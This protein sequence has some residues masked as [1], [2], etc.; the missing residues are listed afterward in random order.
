MTAPQL[1]WLV[2]SGQVGTYDLSPTV[3]RFDP[4]DP[5]LRATPRQRSR[6]RW[7]PRRDPVAALLGALGERPLDPCY[8]G[9][10]D[11]AAAACLAALRRCGAAPQALAAL[12]EEDLGLVFVL[13]GLSGAYVAAT[14]GG[15][16]EALGLPAP[17]L[18]QALV[19][20]TWEGGRP[21]GVLSV[22]RRY[23]ASAGALA[24]LAVTASR[25][26]QEAL[27]A[28]RAHSVVV[29][30]GFARATGGQGRA[31]RR[32]PTRQALPAS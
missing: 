20:V 24:V 1:R 13:A 23:R 29:A 25:T 5:R 12:G 9:D 10:L 28:T 3:A 32:S 21:E 11:L 17:A 19:L 30:P 7:D 4:A 14:R 18:R 8:G 15:P 6:A 22:L 16:G 2:G 27:G 31:L 26:W